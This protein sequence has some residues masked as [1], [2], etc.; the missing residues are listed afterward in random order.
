MFN[1][2]ILLRRF[3]L[4]SCA[5]LCWPL[6]LSAQQDA[7]TAGVTFFEAKIRPVLVKHCYSC[8]SA[9]AKIVRGGLRLDTRQALLR[10]GDSGPG[11]V[12]R[13]PAVSQL[14]S[15]LRYDGLEMPP[16]GKLPA[17]IIADFERWIQM[18]A[19]DPREEVL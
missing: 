1:A 13:K 3:H 18:G 19:P 11:L 14:L 2:M 4:F 5:L 17:S 6:V 8:H 16:E 15:A 7:D 12:P 9:D 10:G